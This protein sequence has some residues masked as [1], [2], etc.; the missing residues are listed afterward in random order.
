MRFLPF[1]LMVYTRFT[2]LAAESRSTQTLRLK[3]IS[4]LLATSYPLL[5]SSLQDLEASVLLQLP[6][7]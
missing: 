6:P 4:R 3:P 2:S 5:G 7:P 1:Q